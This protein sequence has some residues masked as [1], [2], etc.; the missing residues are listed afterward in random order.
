MALP[1]GSE[2]MLRFND[3]DM[4]PIQ[5]FAVLTLCELGRIYAIEVMTDHSGK[6]R[7]D[8]RVSDAFG[9]L[10]ALWGH[11]GPVSLDRRRSCPR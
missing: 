9:V 6:Q 3:G 10:L 5:G 11:F 4:N 1:V 8:M 7:W 2:R